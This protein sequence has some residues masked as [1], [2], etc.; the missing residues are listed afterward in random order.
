VRGGLSK[1][2]ALQAAQAEVRVRW[3]HP[4]FWAGFVL[5]GD[6]GAVGR[7]P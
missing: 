2:A 7:S 3:P 6:G 5:T 1:A 4:F